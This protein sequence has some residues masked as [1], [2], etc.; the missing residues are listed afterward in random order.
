MQYNMDSAA[1][2]YVAY[3]NSVNNAEAFHSIAYN[4]TTQAKWL[5]TFPF[6]SYLSGVS[7]CVC[8]K[9]G[10]AAIQSLRS[11]YGMPGS[12]YYHNHD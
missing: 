1:S 3:Y 4:D 7:L 11:S 6:K 9:S 5:T 12:N 10:R 2:F 8:R